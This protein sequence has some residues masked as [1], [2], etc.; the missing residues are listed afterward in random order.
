VVYL[1]EAVVPAVIV[2]TF[3]RTTHA[4]T[5]EGEEDLDV[6]AV[7]PVHDFGQRLVSAATQK[8]KVTVLVAVILLLSPSISNGKTYNYMSVLH[9]LLRT[10]TFLPIF[11]KGNHTMTRLVSIVDIFNFEYSKRSRC[12]G[13][14]SSRFGMMKK[15]DCSRGRSRGSTRGIS[16]KISTEDIG[17]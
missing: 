8:G 3:P 7:Q 17:P 10:G 6:E 14:G 1:I 4:R 5:S 2:V 16:N 9:E 12:R 11:K 13:R 15:I